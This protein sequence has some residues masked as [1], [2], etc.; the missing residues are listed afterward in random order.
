MSS[1]PQ[2]V[3]V[4]VALVLTPG[5][6]R[7]QIQKQISSGLAKGRTVEE[8]RPTVRNA[9]GQFTKISE[10]LREQFAGLAQQIKQATLSLRQLAREGANA[11]VQTG[12]QVQRDL[13]TQRLEFLGGEGRGRTAREAALLKLEEQ[14][15]KKR[16]QIRDAEFLHQKNIFP[17]T[18][19]QAAKEAERLKREQKIIQRFRNPVS[20]PAFGPIT[21][22]QAAAESR[23]TATK[24]KQIEAFRESQLAPVELVPTGIQKI[25]KSIDAVSTKF[26]RFGNSAHKTNPQISDSAQAFLALGG[27]LAPLNQKLGMMALQ[28]GFSA[29]SMGGVGIALGAMSIAAGAA[30][31]ALTA[32]IKATKA[33]ITAANAAGAVTARAGKSFRELAN[34]SSAL[35]RNLGEASANA[36]TPFTETLGQLKR[37]MADT[38]GVFVKVQEGFSKLFNIILTPIT[39]ATAAF[40]EL[41][42]VI[43]LATGGTENLVEVLIRSVPQ[44][45]QL[46]D[47]TNT[48]S[49]I[50]TT[51]MDAFTKG[52]SE[53]ERTFILSG[54]ALEKFSL[55]SA[56][57]QM[58]REQ[59]LAVARRNIAQS[60]VE[61]QLTQHQGARALQRARDR[62][63]AR[64]FQPSIT[65]IEGAATGIVKE[66]RNQEIILTQRIVNDLDKEIE[67]IGKGNSFLE[68][69]AGYLENLT[70]SQAAGLGGRLLNLVPGFH[71]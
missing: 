12:K 47:L 33:W 68:R 43:E 54:N 38:D 22:E 45:K 4:K 37:A 65:G 36:F 55:Q 16:R 69:I 21:E 51:P 39:A 44:L 50:N 19:L 3:K 53:L 32:W 52:L 9:K 15:A 34:A 61:N 2:D 14:D 71:P 49:D 63:F 31:K 5:Q 26:L 27:I 11:A 24:Q 41:A 6:L 58:T 59:Q 13:R 1:G 70:G 66:N 48:I 56:K 10:P 20:G 29:F 28:L 60:V 64:R 35:G 46:R 67:L 8:I 42:N 25:G 23:K 17:R 57:S 62:I 18:E 40:L 7:R 30:I